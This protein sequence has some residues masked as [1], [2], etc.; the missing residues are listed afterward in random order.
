MTAVEVAGTGEWPVNP[1]LTEAAERPLLRRTFA[2]EVT[3]GDGRTID[4]RLVPFGERITHND[5][6]GGVPRGVDY[7]EEWMP[8]AFDHQLNAAHRVLANVEH[9]PGFGGVVGKGV[10]LRSEP[11][12]YHMSVR[13]LDGPDGDKLLQL[14]PEPLDMV[15]LEA[16]P[17]KS[18]RT[19]GGVVQRVKANLVGLAFT[20]FGAYTGAKVLAVREEADQRIVDEALLPVD[21]DPKLV[22]RLRAQGV[23]LPSRYQAHPAETDTP[24]DAGTSEDGTRQSDDID[25]SEE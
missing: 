20:R 22:E 3:P 14:V 23:E 16:R 7:Q 24:A 13:I 4:V 15:S 9:E 6:L 2:A 25:S 11:D 8:G 18:V 5:G 19:D 17:V 12:G 10:A 21:M 1:E